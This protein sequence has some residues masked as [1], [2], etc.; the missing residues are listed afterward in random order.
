MPGTNP[1]TAFRMVQTIRQFYTKHPSL[2]LFFVALLVRLVYLLFVLQLPGFAI[3]IV[4]EVSYHEMGMRIASGM[5]FE[6]GPFFRPPLW[7]TVV[8]VLYFLVGPYFA[9][10]KLFNLMLGAY[11]VSVLYRVGKQVFSEKIALYSSLY[12]AVYGYFLHLNASGL[13]A[14]LTTFLILESIELTLLAKQ[15]NQFHNYI[16]AG[17]VWALASLAHPTSLVGGLVTFVYL[18]FKRD[19]T[20]KTW[21][22]SAVMLLLGMALGILPVTAR[23]AAENDFVLISSNGGINFY[24]GNN[25]ISEG[26]TAHHPALGIWWTQETAHRWAEAQEQRTLRD[27]EVSS[28]Y[29]R[30]GLQY[31]LAQP[32]DAFRLYVRKLYLA[33]GATEI[34][35]NGDIGFIAKRNLMLFIL[36]KLGYGLVLPFGIAGMIIA[37]KRIPISKYL[38]IMALVFL[39]TP[40]LFFVSARF[41]FQAVPFLCL[42]AVYMVTVMVQT[43]RSS[44]RKAIYLPIAGILVLGIVVNANLLRLPT[45]ENP[46][47]YFINGQVL[48]Q[49]GHLAEAEESFLTCRSMA[50]NVPLVNYYLGEIRR[51]NHDYQAAMDFYRQEARIN[52]NPLAYRGMGLMYRESGIQYKDMSEEFLRLSDSLLSVSAQPDTITMLREYATEYSQM[53]D[54]MRLQAQAFFFR[55]HEMEPSNHEY[56]MLLAQEIGERAIS[57]ADNHQI[58]LA[59]SLFEQAYRIDPQNPFFQFGLAGIAW[60]QGDTLYA[61][62][63]ITSILRRYP[64]Y[65]PAL[66]WREENWRPED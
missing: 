30:Q 44:N 25:E 32:G 46:Y 17:F 52:S 57:A 22:V 34:S 41:R 55:A 11:C 51:V 45:G 21:P 47:G 14:T 31:L 53:A 37:W 2:T 63:L 50:P 29:M 3:P 19:D 28:F 59:K 33:L 26:Y 43:F 56:R 8:G 54:S 36:L 66:S 38:I 24:F 4:D 20:E 62:S 13:G 58:D 35:N 18:Y 23:N 12:F 7:P 49:E 48:Q 6:P 60:E 65:P 39:L 27:S 61:D 42:F 1:V 64:D 10:T 16:I 9:V 15:K 40:V 5:G